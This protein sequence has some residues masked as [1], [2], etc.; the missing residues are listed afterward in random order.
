MN[1]D[2]ISQARPTINPY[3]SAGGLVM[4][5]LRW[6][7]RPQ[8]WSSRHKLRHW[9]DRLAGQKAVIVC[10]GP[11]LLDTDLS[12]LDGVF[13]FGLNKINLLF[14]KSPF[15]PSCIA[16]VNPHVLEQNAAFFNQTEIPLFLAHTGIKHVRPRDNVVF[17]HTADRRRFAR[18][19]SVSLF[20]G[21]TVTY[22][23]LQLAF[24]MGF[25]QVALIGCDHTFATKGPANKL[26][27]AQGSD[28]NHFDP[29]YFA[30]GAKW[31]LPDLAQS[32]VS[33]HLARAEY[34]AAGR[35]IV[36]ATVGGKLNIFPRIDL[37]TFVTT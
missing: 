16:S 8:A 17:V 29:N 30:N 15:R 7:V 26:V 33:Y 18:D 13:T 20:E 12:L 25:S 19:C 4:Q 31:N 32:E 37:A 9:K 27:T 10:N 22:V 21:F 35:R 34:E 2:K 11:S 5:R 36:N 24:H 23:A 14:D 28:P 1:G 6:D 3:V